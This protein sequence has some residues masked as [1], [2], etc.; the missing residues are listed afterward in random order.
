MSE[1]PINLFRHRLLSKRSPPDLDD[2]W[3]LQLP[4]QSFACAPRVCGG[5]RRWNSPY[6]DVKYLYRFEILDLSISDESGTCVNATIVSDEIIISRQ[7]LDLSTW[8]SNIRPLGN[9]T[10]LSKRRTKARKKKN[11]KILSLQVKSFSRQFRRDFCLLLLRLITVY[12]L[13]SSSRSLRRF[14]LLSVSTQSWI[15]RRFSIKNLFHVSYVEEFTNY[16]KS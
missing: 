4:E 3:Q 12:S 14:W 10:I 11:G 5:Y 8:P 16:S 7:N 1:V 13:S 9:L 15:E 2:L 6:L